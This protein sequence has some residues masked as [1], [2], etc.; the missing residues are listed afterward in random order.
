MQTTNMNERIQV[1][2]ETT[3][4]IRIPDINERGK[5]LDHLGLI[6]KAKFNLFESE[7]WNGDICRVV[8]QLDNGNLYIKRLEDGKVAEVSKEKVS[9][10]KWENYSL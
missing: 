8:A 1:Y 3:P 9:L 10:P 4:S 5:M 2:I 7:L 6:V